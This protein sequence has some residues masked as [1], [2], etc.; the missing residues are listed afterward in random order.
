MVRVFMDL[1]ENVAILLAKDRKIVYYEDFDYGADTLD[2]IFSKLTDLGIEE[3]NVVLHGSISEKLVNGDVAVANAF[4]RESYSD[5]RALTHLFS[6]LGIPT[7]FFYEF[8]GYYLSNLEPRT[9][10]IDQDNSQFKL[11]V[12]TDSIQ[13]TSIT[14]EDRKSVV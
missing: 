5:Y 7:V 13:Y 14:T 6:A 9:L 1:A 8:A 2:V 12:Y 3:A 10:L 11:I 4:A